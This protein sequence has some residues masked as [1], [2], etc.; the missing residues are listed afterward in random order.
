MLIEGS[1]FV[2]AGPAPADDVIGRHDVLAAITDRA[3]KGRFVLLTAPRRFGKTTLVR[4]LQHDSEHTKDFAVVIVD[5][6][7][8]H[9]LNDIAVRMAQAWTRLP[10]GP[11]ARAAAKVLPYIAGLEIGGGAVGVNLRNAKPGQSTTLE[12]VLDIPRTV[13]DRT[14]RRVLVV[15]DEFQ[16]VAAVNRADAVIRS[17]IQHQTE[18]VSYLFCGSDQSTTDMLFSDRARPLYGQAERIELGPFDSVELGDYIED[19]FGDTN[20]TITPDALTA[21]LVAVEG[22]PQRAMLLADC[23]WATVPDGGSIDRPELD[24]ALDDAV[25]RCSAEFEATAALL[26]DAQSRT[27]RLAAWGEPLT[28]AAAQRLGLSQGSARSAADGLEDR[29]ILRRVDRRFHHIDP[30]FALWLRRRG[31][32]P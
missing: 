31:P 14:E 18:H 16:S 24:A 4:R 28:G 21:Y 23:L 30:L 20:R 2:V 29:G 7:G 9:T 11:L 19:R 15:L 32:R 25:E 10:A 26:T 3:V 12:A 1:P 22:H 13:A 27:A 8:V 6:L 17:Q 5:L